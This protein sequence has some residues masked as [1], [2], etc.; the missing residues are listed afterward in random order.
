MGAGSFFGGGQPGREDLR[1]IQDE[2]ITIVEVIDDLVKAMTPDGLG[3]P[4]ND[5]EAA[6]IPLGSRV[7]GNETFGYVEIKFGKSR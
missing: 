6:L 3:L 2:D 7:L 5:H 1:V 4:F